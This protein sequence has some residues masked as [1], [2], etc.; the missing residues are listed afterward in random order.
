MGHMTVCPA[1]GS[2][3]SIPALLVSAV[4]R[5][6]HRA[7]M[8]GTLTFTT[9]RT[10]PSPTSHW[11]AHSPRMCHQR[12]PPSNLSLL[13]SPATPLRPLQWTPP[14]NQTPAAASLPSPVPS[15]HPACLICQLPLSTPLLLLFPPLLMQ[16][17]ATL[18]SV[19]PGTIHWT[20]WPQHGLSLC[21]L[22][23]LSCLMIPIPCTLVKMAPSTPL[24]LLL[25]LS[26]M[27]LLPPR[28][29]HSPIRMFSMHNNSIL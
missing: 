24:L 16:I 27:L 2:V 22:S 3:I 26:L 13:S 12:A 15:T 25:L 20:Q 8:G 29:R 9:C 5:V 17:S 18:T 7:G 28:S 23:P 1:T 19:A 14:T 4:T 10:L 6:Q 11:A 21:P